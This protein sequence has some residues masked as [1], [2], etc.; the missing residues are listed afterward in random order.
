MSRHLLL[1]FS[2]VAFVAVLLRSPLPWSITNSPGFDRIAA[3]PAEAQKPLRTWLDE[4]GIKLPWPGA[5][6]TEQPLLTLGYA[7]RQVTALKLPFAAYGDPGSVLFDAR[8]KWG[9]P[10]PVDDETAA[11]LRQLTGR[12]LDAD[13]TFPLWRY[14]WGWLLFVPLVLWAWLQRRAEERR[15]AKAGTF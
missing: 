6:E 8:G 3:V 2:G 13:Y 9:P 15:L 14:V 12:A 10:V 7:Y 11:E 1:A 5:P 4:H